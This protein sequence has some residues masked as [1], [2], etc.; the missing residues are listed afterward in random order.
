MKTKSAVNEENELT[1]CN[2]TKL[3]PTTSNKGRSDTD[4]F[5]RSSNEVVVGTETKVISTI[6]NKGRGDT[7]SFGKSSIEAFEGKQ[8]KITPDISKKRR[9]KS[10]S[11]GKSSHEMTEGTQTKLT[12]KTSNKGRS[13]AESFGKISSE[14]T[15][16][17]QIN[18][19]PKTS[20]S[21]KNGTEIA[22]NSS[23]SSKERKQKSTRRVNLSDSSSKDETTSKTQS[24]E[25]KHRF[26]LPFLEHFVNNNNA[27]PM[28]L[29]VTKSKSS[30]K[31]KKPPLLTCTGSSAAF[32]DETGDREIKI[33]DI[34]ENMSVLKRSDK[35]SPND[36]KKIV[37]PFVVNANGDNSGRPYDHHK[38]DLKPRRPKVH[39]SRSFTEPS[40]QKHRSRPTKSLDKKADFPLRRVIGTDELSTLSTDCDIETENNK[41][42]KRGKRDGKKK[43]DKVQEQASKRKD[44]R[45]EGI[46]NAGNK[47][48]RIEERNNRETEEQKYTPENTGKEREITKRKRKSLHVTYDKENEKANDSNGLKFELQGNHKVPSRR[49]SSHE[50][51]SCS[52]DWSLIES[53]TTQP[54]VGGSIIPESSITESAIDESSNIESTI[55][56][57]VFE[58]PADASGEASRPIFNSLDGLS[59]RRIDQQTDDIK[60]TDLI[61]PENVGL[62]YICLTGK[63][64][65]SDKISN[66][67]QRND[68]E[69]TDSSERHFEDDSIFDYVDSDDDDYDY[70]CEDD[71]GI[72]TIE[73]DLFHTGWRV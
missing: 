22:G 32:E 29:K 70:R 43:K 46:K 5:G 11:F 71:I 34:S 13:N 47:V 65:S 57:H 36:L 24:D 60:E 58:R 37:T 25:D 68:S 59:S 54:E 8:T 30:S 33:I 55:A 63:R 45:R 56:E 12:P 49:M 7:E 18:L 6:S 42:N 62:T 73:G 72:Y 69:E 2:K 26:H 23:S 28:Q 51:E 20:N 31:K 19:T 17:T 4:S 39:R 67:C 15:E 3:T 41:K 1:Q 64:E 52:A 40:K 10:E 9:S 48:E 16:G 14:M 50:A 21:E 35:L 27:Q 61:S 53:S 38:A 66:I 44:N